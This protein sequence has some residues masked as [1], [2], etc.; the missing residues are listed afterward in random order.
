MWHPYDVKSLKWD[1]TSSDILIIDED[2][3]AV[4]TYETSPY[5]YPTKAIGIS[6]DRFPAIQAKNISDVA[7]HPE[8]VFI[9]ALYVVRE[10]DE[11]SEE[12]LSRLQS[13]AIRSHPW[14][15]G[16]EL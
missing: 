16:G 9:A 2:L 12:E 11:L 3:T 1:E 13:G 10:H 8:V 15:F 14:D 4:I 6:R 7:L 5:E